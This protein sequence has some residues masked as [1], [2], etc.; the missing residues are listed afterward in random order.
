MRICVEIM[1]DQKGFLAKRFRNALCAHLPF[2]FILPAHSNSEISVYL[3]MIVGR[4]LSMIILMSTAHHC[5]I[6]RHLH[7][8][9][10]IIMRDKGSR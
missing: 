2:R 7:E 1:K 6:N 3:M 9:R 8:K 4:K 5:I 10:C